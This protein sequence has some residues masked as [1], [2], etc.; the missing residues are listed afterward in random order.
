MPD[1]APRLK[2]PKIRLN[3]EHQRQIW[4]NHSPLLLL[5]TP[6]IYLMLIYAN[7]DA[8]VWLADPQRFYSR[9]SILG[10][11][12]YALSL[13]GLMTL[14]RRSVTSDLQSKFWDQIRMSS[15]TAWQLT[16]TRI[17]SAPHIAWLALGLASLLISY[18][19][20]HIAAQTLGTTLASLLLLTLLGCSCACLMLMHSLQ[21]QRS[22]AEWQGSLLQ[23]AL[24]L[25]MIASNKPMIL[26]V[27]LPLGGLSFSSAEL[28]IGYSL[29]LALLISTVLMISTI[30]CFMHS[31]YLK[32]NQLHW[33]VLAVVSA[34]MLC[35]YQALWSAQPS[36]LQSCILVYSLWAWISLSTQDHRPH[37]WAEAVRHL[38]QQHYLAAI[39]LLPTWL[40]LLP[41]ALLILL[42]AGWVADLAPVIALLILWHLL[43]YA[44]LVILCARFSQKFNA[45]SLA[46]MLYLIY[47]LLFHLL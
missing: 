43:I 47:Q 2:L 44:L 33:H 11:G 1:Q 24:L 35:G 15:L 37:I 34:I 5:A 36:N 29:G 41:P 18:S 9:L 42:L 40:V 46:M 45:I 6:I 14:I 26:P 28:P 30:L 7:Y 12:C 20:Y 38:Q 4:L 39:S 3:A 8:E 31:L 22:N 19:G 25:L 16:W 10:L 23:A 27:Y 32:P 13:F 21:L 17:F